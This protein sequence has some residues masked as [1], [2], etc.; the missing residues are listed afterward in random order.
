M[1]SAMT[2]TA[3]ALM[4]LIGTAPPY[5]RGTFPDYQACVA[6]ARGQVETLQA[7]EG[8][9]VTWQCLPMSEGQDQR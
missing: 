4:V 7:I 6:A 5:Q 2:A 1:D 9:A 8:H 3:F